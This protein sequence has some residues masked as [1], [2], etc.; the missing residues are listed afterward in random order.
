MGILHIV[1]RV[2]AVLPDGQA[3]IKLHL[4]LGLGVEEIAAGV[5]GDLV[6]QVGQGDGLAGTLAHPYHLTVP[7]QL[8]QLHQHDVQPV[9]AVQAQGVHG[10]LQ[11]GHM[12]VVIRAPDVDDLV[13]A[14]DGKLVPVIGDVGGEIGIEPVGPAQ[15]VVL[16]AQ[17]FDV[18]VGL[19]G[20]F[21]ILRQDAAGVQ[22]QGPVLFIGIAQVRQGLDGV[23]HIAAFVEAGLEEPLVIG[24]A[25]AGQVPLHLGNVVVQA[26]AG[27]GVVAGLLVAVQILLALPVIEGLGQLPDVVAVIAVLGELHGVL[28]LDDL[29]IPGLQALGK[30]LDLVAGV[31]DIELPPHVGAGLLQHR[32]QGV[33]QDAAPG[34]A[35]VHGA[36]GVGG[37]ELHHDL[38]ALQGVVA[39]V[40]RPLLLHAG[41]GVPEPLV[42]QA[43][44]QEAR[45]GHLHG[46]EIGPGQVHVVHEDL[47]HLAGVLLQ[48]LGGGQAEGGGVVAVGGILGDL[49]RGD[50]LHAIGQQTLLHGGA[51]GAA[52]QGGDLVLCA[53]DHIHSFFPRSFV[54]DAAARCRAAKSAES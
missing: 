19:A 45:P 10:T 1:H 9:L 31:V 44:I 23:G 8:H 13:E 40:G 46:G 48:G 35:H 15:Y 42:P 33:A 29:Q 51:V 11:P 39:A 53:L 43:E 49:D 20:L 28:A 3:Q 37:D 14:P 4:G 52:R 50:G 38:L 6:Q 24:D 32:G 5:H 47:G 7:Q 30:L 2:L 41:H 18:R 34:V 22:P 12:A 36:G 16:Q 27:Q 26:E 21:Q 54:V 25:V 17:L